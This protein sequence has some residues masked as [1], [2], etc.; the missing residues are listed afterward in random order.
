MNDVCVYATSYDWCM[1]IN[2]QSGPLLISLMSDSFLLV[3]N[4]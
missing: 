4:F 2:E 1:V 3:S